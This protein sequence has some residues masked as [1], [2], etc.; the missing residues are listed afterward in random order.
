MVAN[1]TPTTRNDGRGP[2]LPLFA[3]FVLVLAVLAAHGWLMTVV[4]SLLTEQQAQPSLPER[5]QV[6]YVREMVSAPPVSLA[7]RPAMSPTLGPPMPRPSASRRKESPPAEVAAAAAVVP[8]GVPPADAA[9]SS[10]VASSAQA[11]SSAVSEGPPSE[12][13]V[14]SQAVAA[15]ASSGL[16]GP[17]AAPEHAGVDSVWPQTTRVRYSAKGYYQGD[18]Y[19]DA[20]VEW[21]RQG[22]RYQMHMDVSLGLGLFSRKA[23]SQGRIADQGVRPERYDEATKMPFRSTRRVT[24]VMGEDWVDL[25][26]GQRT[27]RLAGL[28]DTAS[29]FVQLTYLFTTQPELTQAGQRIEFPL[30]F[31]RA[32]RAYAYQ[33]QA[34]EVVQTPFGALDALHVI[35]RRVEPKDR[36]LVAEAWFAPALGYLPVRIRIIQAED[37]YIDLLIAARPQLAE[38]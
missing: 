13:P 17:A 14:P 38:N 21:V 24:L 2:V 6:R 1:L 34:L 11:A 23:T 37:V 10:A 19:G 31:P 28:Q 26:Q 7:R 35:P 3:G 9:A 29:Q 16:P 8:D 12:T 4:I 20:T 18:I 36:D 33:V 30:V 15:G 27:A 5:V 32:V 25:A 22:N